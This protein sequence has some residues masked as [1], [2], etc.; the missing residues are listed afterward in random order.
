MLEYTEMSKNGRMWRGG[1]GV[2]SFH[3]GALAGSLLL[4]SPDPRA[5]AV[6]AD[7]EGDPALVP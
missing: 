5:G 3:S 7:K 6:E 4:L 1:G 2:Y